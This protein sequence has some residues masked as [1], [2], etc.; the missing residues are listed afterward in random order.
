MVPGLGVWGMKSPKQGLGDWSPPRPVG[1][2]GGRNVWKRKGA[3]ARLF[4]FLDGSPILIRRK[5]SLRAD[6]EAVYD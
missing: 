3:L 6:R 2:T 5:R 1:D 4:R